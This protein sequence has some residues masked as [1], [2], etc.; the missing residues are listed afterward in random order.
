MNVSWSMGKEEMERLLREEIHKGNRQLK[1]VSH[2][3]IAVLGPL[4]S[5]FRSSHLVIL[6]YLT[7][8]CI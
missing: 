2:T 4:V 8:H 3:R 7:I 1:W 5:S 6:L